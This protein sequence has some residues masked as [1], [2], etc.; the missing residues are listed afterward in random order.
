MRKAVLFIISLTLSTI[1]FGQINQNQNLTNNWRFGGG[2]GL[3]FGNDSYFGFNISPSIGYMVSTNLEVGGI[4]GYQHLSN[5]YYKRNLFN[6][7]PYI[8]F[9]Q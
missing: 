9:F 1:A 5:N 3:S 2:L 4:A 7:G 6:V 8:N